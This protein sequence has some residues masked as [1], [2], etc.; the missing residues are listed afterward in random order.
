MLMVC[1]LAVNLPAQNT[2][3]AAEAT[4]PACPVVITGL[5]ARAVSVMGG[6]AL[7]VTFLNRSSE[8]IT[9]MSFQ[10]RVGSGR[11]RIVP[12][13][14]RHSIAPGVSETE[15]WN[16]SPWLPRFSVQPQVVVWPQL[17]TFATS[18]TWTNGNDAVR[19]SFSTSD[20]EV[21]LATARQD[22]VI[23]SLPGNS[24]TVA[25]TAA[26]KK[27]LIASGKASLCSVHTYPEGAGVAVD[28]QSVGLAPL[29][30]V[31]K[32]LDHPRT[33]LISKVGYDIVQR[34]V[35]P[36]GSRIALNVTL[37]SLLDPKGANGNV[38]PE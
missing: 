12:L 29:T 11:G 21:P 22:A 8:T 14:V 2:P 4:Q 27:A 13:L 15:Q 18:P 33:I 38:R 36:D 16:D 17:V 5:N 35:K 20:A 37:N 9:G 34:T 3:R 31:I 19:C 10:A 6:T 23:S 25:M 30:M 7:A 1:G 26:Q 28:G 32:K 24:G